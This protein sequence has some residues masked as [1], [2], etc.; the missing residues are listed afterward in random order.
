VYLANLAGWAGGVRGVIYCHG[1]NG[2]AT[3]CRDYSNIGELHLVNAI[4]EV[5]PVLSIDAGGATPWGN[6]TAVARVDDAI[7]YGQGTLGWES[8]TVLLVAASMGAV[9]ALNYTMAHPTK[10]A[11]VVG[12][13]PVVDVNDVVTNNRAGLAAGVNT[14]Y[15]GTYSE[16][17][18]GPTSNPANYAASMTVPT[19]LFYSSD[20]T[21]AIPSAVTDYAAAAANVTATSLGALGHTQA[22]IDA[23]PREQI[24]HFL[25]QYA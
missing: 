20:D 14:A 8:G 6:G 5:F 11:A 7:D 2:S 23:A 13:I 22:A 18:D 17:T 16:V 12:I 21:T 4:A 3:T 24:L 25:G 19:H 10:V 9:T 15:G 1:A